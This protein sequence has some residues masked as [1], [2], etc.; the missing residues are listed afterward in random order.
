MPGRRISRVARAA[1]A[2][3]VAVLCALALPAAGPAYAQE[4]NPVSVWTDATGALF[5]A[6]NL[7]PGTTLTTC[8]AVSY[9]APGATSLRM[10]APAAT[11]DLGEYLDLQVSAGVGGGYGD[12]AAFSGDDVYFGTLAGFAS[13][14]PDP[15][16]GLPLNSSSSTSGTVTVRVT[17]TLRDENGAQGKETELAFGWYAL[18]GE[19]VLRKPIVRVAPPS[20]TVPVIGSGSAP[21]DVAA[22]SVEPSAEVATPTPAPAPAPAAAGTGSKPRKPDAELTL[23]GP[24]EGSRPALPGLRPSQDGVSPAPARPGAKPAEPA[25]SISLGAA[26]SK[27]LDDVAQF[28]ERAAPA[29]IKGARLPLGLLGVALLFLIVQHEIDRRDPKLALAP[30]YAD[31]LPFDYIPT[32]IEA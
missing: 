16:S 20:A 32:E 18:D 31:D 29:V 3:G 10:A 25:K 23:P 19:T 2:V 22:P 7:T 1:A 17:I 8:V 27:G 5:N 15:A 21:T 4:P 6:T 13:E 12:C 30:A 11:G 28:V 24:A 26:I 9:S 14:Y